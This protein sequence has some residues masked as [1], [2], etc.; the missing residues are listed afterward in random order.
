MIQSE[1]IFKDV[2]FEVNDRDL[3]DYVTSEPHLHVKN[4]NII[5]ARLRNREG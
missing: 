5:H 4:I 3:M 2:P 1:K